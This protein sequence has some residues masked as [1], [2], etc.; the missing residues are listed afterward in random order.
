MSELF[1][2]YPD[3]VKVHQLK[4]MLSIGC[5]TAYNLLKTGQIKHRRVGSIYLI[6]KIYVVEYVLNSA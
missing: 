4:E 3:C 1:K 2:D 6:P 5:N